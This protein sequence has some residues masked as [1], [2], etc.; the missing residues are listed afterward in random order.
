MTK[1]NTT[2]NQP[3]I[4]TKPMTK[5]VL[6][7]GGKGG[8]GKTTVLV[9][10]TDYLR[11]RGAEH[12]L[13]DCDTENAHQVTCFSHWLGG[14]ENLLN[15]RDANDRDRLLT[16]SA[17][18]GVPYVLADL[19]ANA[20]GDISTWLQD[21]AT[22]DI[23]SDMG[24]E[25]L[26]VGVV[27]P[28]AGSAISAVQWA[29]TLGDRA[30]YLIAL[31]RI[32]YEPVPRP[33]QKVF[34]EWFD[35]AVPMLEGKVP[36]D[37]IHTIDI[38]NMEAHGMLAMVQLGKLPSKALQGSELNLLHKSRVKT[39]RNRIFAELDKTGLFAVPEVATK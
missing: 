4:Q 33:A 20:T 32:E 19:P 6:T 28:Q 11:S 27:T 17:A 38:P 31:N 5:I 37:R 3:D 16:D 24:L 25:I 26:A 18:A 22:V 30:R 14:K 9:A 13:M 8:V 15:L 36:A 12:A 39:W 34:A 21:V 10:I 7:C 29:S 23:I 1:K 35:V 2:E